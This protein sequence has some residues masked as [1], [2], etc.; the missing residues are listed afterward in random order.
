MI[1]PTFVDALSRLGALGF[2]IVAIGAFVT[3]QVHTRGELRDR[4]A[5]SDARLGEMRSDRDEWKNI[6]KSALTKLDRL[7]D[8][9]EASTGKPFPE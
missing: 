6:A 1:D 8:V 4:L 5:E 3:R 7:T 9:L 2:A